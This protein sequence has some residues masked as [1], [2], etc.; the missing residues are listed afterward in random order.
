MSCRTYTRNKI[1]KIYWP[2]AFSC[3]RFAVCSGSD[4]GCLLAPTW[5]VKGTWRQ[6]VPRPA[7]QRTRSRMDSIKV[8]EVEWTCWSV[9]LAAVLASDKS[10]PAIDLLSG[11][12]VYISALWT[13]RS[14]GPWSPRYIAYIA[15]L[16]RSPW[17]GRRMQ[18]SLW[19]WDHS[20]LH[21][22]NVA[23]V[24]SAPSDAGLRPSLS[25]FS[26]LDVQHLSGS[27]WPAQSLNLLTAQ[28][29]GV[30]WR[31]SSVVCRTPSE[32]SITTG[33]VVDEIT[34]KPGRGKLLPGKTTI[35]YEL[36]SR[37]GTF[38]LGM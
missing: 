5:Q 10:S 37:C 34:L 7:V 12:A 18:L 29:Q 24:L 13:G 30:D 3:L 23:F 14:A 26:V 9:H 17:L 25:P 33:C 4:L 6:A 11:F 15:L 16:Y 21:I 27:T 38:Y 35:R 28:K 31:N 20:S 32:R 22:I 8:S 1:R 36:N 19:S 2:A